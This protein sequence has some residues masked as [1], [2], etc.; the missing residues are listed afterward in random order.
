MPLF[1]G[2]TDLQGATIWLIGGTQESGQV[3]AGL[4]EAQIPHLVTVVTA[5]AAGL[6]PDSPWRQVRVGAIA[7]KAM[8][9]VLMAENIAAVI[10]ASHPFAVEVS[11]SAISLCKSHH[12]PYLRLE[13]PA[14]G[15]SIPASPWIQ[16]VNAYDDLLNPA[17]LAPQAR[18]LLTVG[19]KNLHRFQP[20]HRRTTLFA[21]I[22]PRADSL[23]RA[24]AAGFTPDRIIAIRP[25]VSAD[26]ER[27]LWQQWHITQVITKASGAPGGEAIKRSLAQQLKVRLWILQRPPLAYPEQTETPAGA[28]AFCRRVLNKL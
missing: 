26:L 17:V 5:A 11:R 27:S 21:R 7:P 20:W 4:A 14:I 24:I 12:L 2:M 16:T 1:A 10:D 15:D 19:A 23:Q 3:A 8:A 6:Y 22:L 25:P 9:A 28:I 18:S 13:R